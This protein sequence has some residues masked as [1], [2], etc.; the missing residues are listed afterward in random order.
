M[1]SLLIAYTLTILV[2][3]MID[4]LWLGLIAKKLYRKYLGHLL[5]NKVNWPAAII[6]YFIYIAGISYFAIYP[7]IDKDSVQTAILLGALLGFFA[8]ATYDLTNLA[9]LKGWPLSI[10]IIDIVWGIVLSTAVSVA[11]FY[12]VKFIN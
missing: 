10:V 1:K 5:S 3:L 8:Y 9:T 11:G 12:I 4:L 2:F 7:A 6:F